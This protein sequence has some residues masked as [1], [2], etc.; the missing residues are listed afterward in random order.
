M[1]QTNSIKNKNFRIYWEEKEQTCRLRLQ[2]RI[3]LDATAAK[4][5]REKQSDASQRHK[6]V[7]FRESKITSD[8]DKAGE[9]LY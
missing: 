4:K 7:S 6:Y 8:S 1:A 3:K 9:G 5:H 2:P